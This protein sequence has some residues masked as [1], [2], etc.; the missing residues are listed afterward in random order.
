MEKYKSNI[1]RAY[2]FDKIVVGEFNKLAFESAKLCA[3]NPGKQFNPLFIYGDVGVGKTFLMH[4]IGNELKHNFPGYKVLYVTS[5]KFV[6]DFIEA[7]KSNSV[8]EFRNKYRNVDCLLIDDIQFLAGKHNSQEEFVNLFN[9]LRDNEKQIVISSDWTQSLENKLSS[10]FKFGKTVDI[11][12]PNLKTKIAIL[13]K[14]AKEEN[15]SLH[16]D[17]MHF[18]AHRANNIRELEG[19]LL[20]LAAFF[21]FTQTPI[22]LDATKRVFTDIFE[23]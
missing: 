20:R 15:I 22:T 4:A 23:A 1:N 16:K 9:T 17:I 21:K 7:V 19:T 14:K 12:Q 18:I 2:S 13:N 6:Y 11:H 8:S 3:E 10:I 5:E